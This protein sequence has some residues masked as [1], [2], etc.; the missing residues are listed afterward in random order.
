MNTALDRLVLA[1]VVAFAPPGERDA[2]AGELLEAAAVARDGHGLAREA[3]RSLPALLLWRI[4][5]LGA[6]PALLA[7]LAGAVSAALVYAAGEAF[8]HFVLSFVPRRA[9]HAMPLAWSCTWIT[10]AEAA[11]IAGAALGARL[12]QRLTGGRRS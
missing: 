10:L 8:W 7:L 9:G 6:R 1:A 11:G 2:L 4:R 5:R 12:G 3:L